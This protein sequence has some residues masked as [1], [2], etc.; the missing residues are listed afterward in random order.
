MLGMIKADAKS[1]C[2]F[3]RARITAQ[4]MARAAGRNIPAAGFRARRM[5][6]VASCMSVKACWYGERDAASRGAVTRCATYAA[7]AHVARVIEFHPEAPQTRK[8][9]QRTRLHVRMTNCA[10]GTVGI[11]KLLRVA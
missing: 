7:H 9:F 4:L 11:R 1:L 6:T 8:G 2:E 10:D 5:T 3:R